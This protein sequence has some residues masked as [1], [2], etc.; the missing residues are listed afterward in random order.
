MNISLF[1]KLSQGVM[2][3]YNPKIQVLYEQNKRRPSLILI[4]FLKEFYAISFLGNNY[5]EPYDKVM[6]KYNFQG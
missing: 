6:K 1:F 4:L 5:P 2:E 3:A